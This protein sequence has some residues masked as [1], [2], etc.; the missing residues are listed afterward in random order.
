M[1]LFIAIL[2]L[3]FS[4][5]LQAQEN[6]T[7]FDALAAAYEKNST[8]HAA[9]MEYKV[10]QEQLALAQTGFNPTVTGDAD[11]TYSNTETQ[12]QSFISSD[13]G[14][15]SK[16]ASLNVNQPLFRGGSTLADIREAKNV[17][18]AQSLALSDVE[19][20]VLYDA[21]IAYM[22]L[23]QTHSI[24]QLNQQN[25]AL[26]LRELQ[27]AQAGFD[28][29]E[30]TRTDVSQAQARLAQA[31]AD[32]ITVE[33][34]LKKA[35]AVYERIV[36]QSFVG[37]P[38]KPDKQIFLP[39]TLDDAISYAQSNN[40]N[41]LRAKFITLA[42][43]DSVDSVKGELLPQVSALGSAGR[44]Y[45]QSD[46][47]EEQDQVSVGVAV[48]IP[49]YEAGAT[50]VRM[51]EAKKRAN[52][53]YLE[54]VD[55]Q[56]KAKEEAITNWEALMATRAEIIARQS[57]I[58]AARIAQEGVTLETELGERTVLDKLNANQELLNAEVALVTAKRDEVVAQFALA[59]VLGL[60]VPQKLGFSSINP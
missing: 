46:F 56:Q 51:R 54:V 27:E 58:E 30:L 52:Q 37:V 8:L 10:T 57:Q 2:I 19:Q 31:K 32:L 44:V 12:G 41:V 11:M 29:G 1:R 9:R 28:V 39:E 21:A 13:G 26:I 20:S 60:L 59:R 43:R 53:R 5:S 22:D 17:I 49:L 25:T 14:N 16:S 42:A 3:F 24:V 35:K 33:G 45:D 7:I 40:R 50:Q 6:I 36:G 18:T 15:T 23:V 38:V 47:I 34:D 4:F 55:V 48:S